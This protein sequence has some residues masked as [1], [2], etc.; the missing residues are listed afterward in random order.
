[1]RVLI[2]R[3]ESQARAMADVLAA[4]G[5][6]A[7]IAPMLA[8]VAEPDVVGSVLDGH[9]SP[10]ALVFTS[11]AGVDSLAADQRRGALAAIPA[12]AVGPATAAA[13]RGAGFATVIDAAGDGEAVVRAVVA[14]FD[15]TAGP[16]VHVGA[17]ERAVDV[18]DR[19]AEAGFSARTVVAYRTETVAAVDPATAA[20]VAAGEFAAVVVASARTA[21]AFGRWLER[22]GIAVPA[23][24]AL[25]AISAKAAAPLR[26]FFARLVIARE[27]SGESLT[28]AVVAL[29]APERE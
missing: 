24:T 6:A 17:R 4:D 13:A 16:V 15:P 20:D 2:L 27:P 14:A 9:V 23:T 26:P 25:A 8:V 22:A 21:E 18:A 10:Q 1:M 11:V 5:V 29:R 19:L 7:T 12:V 28:K 3:P